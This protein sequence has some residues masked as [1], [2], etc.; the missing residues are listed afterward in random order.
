MP[1][2]KDIPEEAWIDAANTFWY[3]RQL[4]SHKSLTTNLLF[5]LPKASPPAQEAWRLHRSIV[6]LTWKLESEIRKRYTTEEYNALLAKYGLT[7]DQDDIFDAGHVLGPW[8][9][10][11]PESVQTYPTLKPA[12]PPPQ[13]ATP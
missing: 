10:P 7:P 2:L 13:P 1:R 6:S 5:R 11:S 9:P 12:T 3:L 8:Q 4:W